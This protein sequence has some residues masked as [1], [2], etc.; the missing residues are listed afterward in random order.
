MS[1]H[2]STQSLSPSLLSLLH[3]DNGVDWAAREGGGGGVRRGRRAPRSAASDGGARRRGARRRHQLLHRHEAGRPLR[4]LAN[5][6]NSRG[7]VLHKQAAT[8]VRLPRRR[9]LLCAPRL[10]PH[11][12]PQPRLAPPC[13]SAPCLDGEERVK[14]WRED[15]TRSGP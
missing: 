2:L 1:Y 6:I 8:T 7:G 15:K 4:D 9:T 14:D 3:R 13:L 10:P 11:L 12:T 5:H